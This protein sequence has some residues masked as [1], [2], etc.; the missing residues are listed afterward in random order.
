MRKEELIKC[1]DD[2]QRN[3]R[4]ST[5]KISELDV[6]ADIEWLK[7]KTVEAIDK[8]QVG[9]LDKN[10]DPNKKHFYFTQFIGSGSG[11]TDA[12]REVE[13]ELLSSAGN[14][15]PIV[16]YK[17]RYFLLSWNDILQLAEN[18]GLFKE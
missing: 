8:L 7:Q 15:A 6:I 17:N 12:G 14:G 16:Q 13:Y 9:T 11:C 18:A 2:R 1:F 5:E 4:S 10:D 3:Y